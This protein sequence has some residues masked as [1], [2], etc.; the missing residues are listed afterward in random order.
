MG[1]SLANGQAQT[2]MHTRLAVGA[3][4]LHRALM[5]DRVPEDDLEPIYFD[6][7][8]ALMQARHGAIY[9]IDDVAALL[10]VFRPEGAVGRDLEPEFEH[11]LQPPLRGSDARITHAG[12]YQ[13]RDV[14]NTQLCF[15]LLEQLVPFRQYEWSA[16]PLWVMAIEVSSHYQ[17]QIVERLGCDTWFVGHADIGWPNTLRTIIHTS[18]EHRWP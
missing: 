6:E 4:R 7:A 1:C 8:G 11:R 14:S 3:I 17:R 10:L 12:W 13:D 18:L 15:A 9:V 2:S 5:L 16:R